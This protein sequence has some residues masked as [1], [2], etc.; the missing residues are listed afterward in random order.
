MSLGSIAVWCSWLTWWS[1]DEVAPV[2]V[3]QRSHG[4]C[5][6]VPGDNICAEVMCPGQNRL[7]RTL[8]RFSWTL[9]PTSSNNEGACMQE[10]DVY[11]RWTMMSDFPYLVNTNKFGVELCKIGHTFVW[12]RQPWSASYPFAGCRGFCLGTGCRGFCL[13][14]G[15]WLR[16]T[17]RVL[18][19]SCWT[20]TVTDVRLCQ[21]V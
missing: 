6:S 7:T 21:W 16:V 11:G 3:N 17:T 18:L 14:T 2:T 15:R 20:Q 4:Y 5:K 1:A 12:K 13:G 8:C 10:R 19:V 9:N